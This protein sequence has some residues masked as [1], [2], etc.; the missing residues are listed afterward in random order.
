MYENIPG[1]NTYNMPRYNYQQQKIIRLNGRAGAETL[2]LAPNSE[3]LALDENEPVLWVIQT[4]GAGYKTITPFDI[5]PHV[6]KA[7]AEMQELNSRVAGIEQAITA[8]AASM[9]E[10]KNGKSNLRNVKKQQ[11][12]REPDPA[13]Q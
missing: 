4:D 7:Q 12:R 5:S 10:L 1:M 6:E 11:G 13:N 3:T 8:L 2:Q 9:E